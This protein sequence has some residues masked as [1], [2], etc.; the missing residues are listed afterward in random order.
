ME[1]GRI[2]II[3]ASAGS[4][5]TYNLARTFI[6]HLI[7]APTGT[8]VRVNDKVYEQFTLHKELN[9]H[10]HLLAIT[11]TNKATNEMKDRI[12]K[13]LHLLSTGHGDYVNDFKI[14]F[15]G[16]TFS[17][18]VDAARKALCSILFDYAN[19]N[20]S[21]IDSFFQSVLRNFAR[22]LDHDYNYEVQLDHDYATSVAVHDFL[23]ELG[24]TGKK[25]AA[26]NNWVKDFINNN[27]IIR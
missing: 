23:L 2:K 16:C 22:E 9:Y 3:K 12:I 11:F 20:V 4:G 19:F 25:H 7:G 1:D 14:M 6:A 13:E 15:V 18:V 10:R 24:A 17:N 21:T 27:I 26:I 8:T 5:K